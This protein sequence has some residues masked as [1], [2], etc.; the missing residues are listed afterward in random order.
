M[1]VTQA[2]QQS[3]RMVRQLGALQ[4]VELQEFARA[5]AAVN[6]AEVAKLYAV[7][8]ELMGDMRYHLLWRISELERICAMLDR[9]AT[10][11]EQC[12]SGAPSEIREIIAEK[13]LNAVELRQEARLLINARESR[14]ESSH[15]EKGHAEYTRPISRRAKAITRFHLQPNSWKE[16]W[17][18]ST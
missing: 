2:C 3:A 6:H 10:S 14:P 9:Y 18:P 16:R 12:L 17:V 5:E 8:D 11:P 1:S 4:P 7:C 15:A 13:V